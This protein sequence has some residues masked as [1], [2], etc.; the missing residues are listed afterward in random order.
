MSSYY[1]AWRVSALLEW[2]EFALKNNSDYLLS[3]DQHF[4]FSEPTLQYMDFAIF[5]W[6]IGRAG[7]S[8]RKVA[9]GIDLIENIRLKNFQMNFHRK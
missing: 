7:I 2:H 6:S 3:A 9:V 8:I 5:F 1:D 4:K